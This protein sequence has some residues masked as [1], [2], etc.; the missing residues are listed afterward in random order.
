MSRFSEV[1]ITRGEWEARPPKSNDTT[2]TKEGGIVVHH[3]AV[4]RAG[5]THWPGCYESMRG[6]QRYHM[7]TKGWSDI[8]YNFVVCQHGFIFEG[9]GFTRQNAAN[10]PLNTSTLSVCFDG[11]T[12]FEEPGLAAILSINAVISEAQARGWAPLVRGHG[13]A[14]GSSSCPGAKLQAMI[15]EG[16]IGASAPAPPVPSVPTPEPDP[17]PSEPAPSGYSLTGLPRATVRQMQEWARGKGATSTFVALAPIFYREAT[18]LSLRPEFVYALAAHETAFGRFGGVIDASFHN[19]GGLKIPSGGG[20]FDPDAHARFPD[21]AT[22]VRAV[23]QHVGLYAGVDVP[24]S[25]IVDPRWNR[26]LLG[27]APTLPSNG[28]QWSSSPA[29]H[30]NKILGFVATIE[31]VS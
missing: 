23:C 5:T 2:F 30:A 25:E 31:G 27:S 13:Q 18:A 24:V 3:S 22:G 17:Q 4:R 28:W 8:A 14:T 20:N 26:S 21:D 9:R 10:Q 7:D 29:A 19:W 6:H 12:G 15:S 11:N 16:T 1:T